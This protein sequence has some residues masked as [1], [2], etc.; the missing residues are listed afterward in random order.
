MAT[1]NSSCSKNSSIRCTVTQCQHHC[2]AEN[3]CSLPNIQIGTHESN[4][5]MCQCTD[6]ESFQL[7]A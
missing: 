3:Y 7:K 2:N 1:S 6:C 4:P 5:T